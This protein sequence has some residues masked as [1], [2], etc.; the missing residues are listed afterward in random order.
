MAGIE[1]A[2]QNMLQ[3]DASFEVSL[4]RQAQHSVILRQ[5]EE[6]LLMR[7]RNDITDVQK[8]SSYLQTQ[9][10]SLLDSAQAA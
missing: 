1:H 10:T 3:H 5:K 4:A 9:T 6:D 8:R 2:S 7:L